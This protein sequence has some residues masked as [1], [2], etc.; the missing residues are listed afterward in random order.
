MPEV[1][2]GRAADF[3]ESSR[4]V[5]AIGD[6]EVGVFFFDGRFTA[7]ENRCPHMGGPACQGKILPRVTEVIAAD[8]TSEGF[9]FAP[10]HNVICPWHGYEYDIA[11]GRHLG[12]RRIRL[13]PV[14]LRVEGGEVLVA[15]P[16]AA[17]KA[18]TAG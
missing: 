10:A 12:D 18:A 8:G 3:P 1:S 9:A 6:L 11:T 17:G 2:I 16:A 14:P 13:R 15:I 5:V 7:Y 4:R